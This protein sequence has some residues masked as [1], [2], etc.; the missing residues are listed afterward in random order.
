MLAPL[1]L[2]VDFANFTY[3]TNPCFENVPVPVVMRHGEFSYVDKNAASFD[4]RVDSVRRGSLRT[5]TKQAVVVLACEFPVGGT[6]AAYVF[7]VR[8]NSAR[9][10]GKVAEADWGADW[11]S[12]PDSIH[13]R[14]AGHVL[15]VNGARYML[16]SGRLVRM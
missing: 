7:D 10:L 3:A 13:V 14:F 15:Y 2:A 5:G 8:G 1:V 16:K 6:A 12:G 9:L 4:L 11:G